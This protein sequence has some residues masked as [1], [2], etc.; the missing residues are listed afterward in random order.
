[1]HEGKRE[2]TPHTCGLQSLH[3][4]SWPLRLGIEIHGVT[5]INMCVISV[6]GKTLL[7]MCVKGEGG[8]NKHYA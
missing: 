4:S 1:M 3:G 6:Y 2:K 7:C 5:D 8:T